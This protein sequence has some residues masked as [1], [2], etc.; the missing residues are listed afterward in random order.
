[1]KCIIASPVACYPSAAGNAERVRQLHAC[2]ENLG[3]EVHFVLCPIQAMSTQL[4]E[5]AMKQAFGERFHQLN[6]HP[7]PL[8][9]ALIKFK[10]RYYHRI[11]KTGWLFDFMFSD[12]YVS[13]QSCHI[14]NHLVEEIKPDLIV[15][16]YGF[17]S[18]LVKQLDYRSKV[19]VDAQ[20]KF[21]Y[22]NRGIRQAGSE[23]YWLSLLPW[24]ER[25]LLAQ[26]DIVLAIQ[27]QE[28]QFF[29]MLLNNKQAQVF[30]LDITAAPDH[31]EVLPSKEPVI[32][33]LASG[34]NHNTEGLKRFIS[35]VWPSILAECPNATLKVAG[36]VT[37]N[38]SSCTS[39]IELIGWVDDLKTFY[40]QCR[41]I[42][43]PCETGSGLKIKTIEA[44]SFGI[45][46]VSTPCG[47]A[48]VEFL[49][50]TAHISP[51]TDNQFSAQCIHLLSDIESAQNTANFSLMKMQKRA[52]HNIELLKDIISI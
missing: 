23:G 19:L 1:M 25:Y 12:G 9:N 34:N 17:M 38:I 41:L 24:Q 36:S 39:N 43:N 5:P 3:Y 7:R 32:G 37:N 28:S 44:V 31:P 16:V 14:F 4:N 8:Q 50:P 2:L 46:V 18:P 21:S 20:D 13:R 48:G 6:N 33:F 51:L 15:L 52:E 22:R 45:P 26:S 10:R 29:K 30:T 47:A 11:H 42:I 35:E 49:L 27:E 40:Q